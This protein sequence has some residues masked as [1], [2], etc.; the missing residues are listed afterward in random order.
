MVP[1]WIKYVLITLCVLALVPPALIARARLV[2]KKHP[3]IHIIQNMDNQ[4]KF[5]GQQPNLLFNDGR[6]MRPR[7]AG[8]IAQGDMVDDTHYALGVHEGEWVTAFPKQIKITTDFVRRGQERFEIYCLPCHGATGTGDG[9]IN[10]RAMQLME[11]GLP[12]GTTWVQVKN[13][14]E[15]QIVEQPLGQIF[16][17]ITNGVRNMAGYANQINI[18]DR[19]AIVA[20]VKALQESRNANPATVPNADS[21]P[22]VVEQPPAASSDEESAKKS[23]TDSEATP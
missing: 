4:P 9:I 13:I 2:P 11:Q 16:N 12:S 6:S 21:L 7:V 3:R 5:V 10:Q 17:T 15:A 1:R 22:R 20:Y 14:H 8:T 23:D 18:E 19:W